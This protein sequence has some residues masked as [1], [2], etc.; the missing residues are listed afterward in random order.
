MWRKKYCC[1]PGLAKD[2]HIATDVDLCRTSEPCSCPTMHI[3][4]LSGLMFPLSHIFPQSFI[5]PQSVSCIAYIHRSCPG[6]C[7]LLQLISYFSS[8]LYLG[9]HNFLG[10]SYSWFVF[11]QSYRRSFAA[12]VS[13]SCFEVALKIGLW[14]ACVCTHLRHLL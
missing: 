9:T 12:S 5:L 2:S 14:T 8:S 13:L 11:L 7:L 4:L 3:C 1:L 6:L 10:Y